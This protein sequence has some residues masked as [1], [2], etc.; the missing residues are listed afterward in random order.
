[1]MKGTEPI[2][3]VEDSEE[4]Y[5]T[6]RRLLAKLTP[7]RIE[8]C[9]DVPSAIS[10]LRSASDLTHTRHD[11]WPCII[12]LDLNI[13]GEDGRSLLAWL[14]KDERLRPIPVVVLT[15]SSNPTDVDFCY[16][17]G[18]A[19]YIVKPMDLTRFRSSLESLAHYW[20]A[21]VTLPPPNGVVT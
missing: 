5:Q 21:S 6:A 10:Y 17:E 4:D 2:L 11:S 13:P 20:L 12:L 9:S 14:K 3:I 7:R 18:A 19:G 8:R 1:M 15:T 16:R